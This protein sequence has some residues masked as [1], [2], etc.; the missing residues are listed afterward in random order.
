MC[1]YIAELRQIESEVASKGSCD[2]IIKEKD[3]L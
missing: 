3:E 2:V 1:G